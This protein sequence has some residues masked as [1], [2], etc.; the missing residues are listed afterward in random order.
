MKGIVAILIVTLVI[1][2]T[3]MIS[4]QSNINIKKAQYVTNG[5]KLYKTH[6]ENCHGSKGEGLGK[7]YP[8]LTD[9]KYLEENRSLLSCIVRHGM[10][11]EIVIN[12]IKY[13]QPMP[14]NQILTDLDIA[15]I[16]TYVTT[17]FGGQDS[18]Y[19]HEEVKENLRKCNK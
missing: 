14:S 6:C 1:F 19:S 12:G 5:L 8:P 4:C 7:L 2:M 9:K 13:N 17:N 16:L 11:K 10:H 15:Y 18:I 3:N